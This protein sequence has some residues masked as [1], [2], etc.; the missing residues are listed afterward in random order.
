MTG[1]GEAMTKK[2]A[3][4]SDGTGNSSASP[5]KTNVWR[6]YEALDKSTGSNQIAFYDNGVGT[7][8]F[9][10]L[11]LLGLGLG[12]GLARNVK[13]IYA[14]LCQTYNDGDEIYC[15]G[16]SRG[17]FTIRVVVA[18]I[19]SQG[20]IDRN[21]A[22]DDRDL[23]RLVGDAY[24]AFR[25]ENF[26]PSILSWFLSPPR[27]WI[28]QFWNCM[29]GRGIYRRVDNIHFQT[30]EQQKN[31]PHKLIKFVGVWDSVDAY[32]LPVDEMTKA[33]DR[34][35]WPFSAKD[36]DLSKR[37]VKACH[38]LALDEQRESFE[39]MLW[40]E[41]AEN[42]TDL[43]VDNLD[44]Q[45][46]SQ[47]WFPGVHANVG[48]GYPDDTL[49]Y[50]SLNWILDASTNNNGL[51]YRKDIRDKYKSQA[52]G[53]LYNNRSGIA[54]LYRYAPR[55]IGA[56]CDQI[57][58]E[59]SN[60]VKY[61]F[62]N[63]DVELN[64][65]K[66]QKP[67]IHFSV[68]ERIKHGGDGYAPINLPAKYAI[69]DTAGHIF[70]CNSP[71]GIISV[72][73]TEEQ[74]SSRYA[75]QDFI[76][77]KVW[78]SRA[79]HFFTL[80]SAA[81]FIAFPYVT[82]RV[83]DFELGRTAGLFEAI[84]GV[85]MA[86]IKALPELVGQIPGLGFASGWAKKYSFFPVEFLF[87]VL[88]LAGLLVGNWLLGLS[89]RSEMRRNFYHLTNSGQPPLEYGILART[90]RDLRQS[91]VFRFVFGK[92]LSWLIHAASWIV[93][94]SAIPI[95][96][97]WAVFAALDGGGRV[98]SSSETVAGLSYEKPIV[99]EF[100]PK[101]PCQS[102][103]VYLDRGGE[104]KI[105]FVV[106]YNP[107]KVCNP[108]KKNVQ[109]GKDEWCY[110]GIRADVN[111][112]R[113][114]PWYMY[115]ATPFKRHLFADFY[116]PIARID[117]KLFT[118]YPLVDN[119]SPVTDPKIAGGGTPYQKRLCM[120]LK[121][122]RS[123]ELFFFVNDAVFLSPYWWPKLFCDKFEFFCN[124]RGMAQITI[125]RVASEGTKRK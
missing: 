59:F 103:K 88:L 105:E 77:N 102:S 6:A 33:W 108:V 30:A 8:S 78:R 111:G 109:P 2:I 93:F 71:K 101:E 74:A 95:A 123:G 56:L 35:V 87:G 34:V 107:K 115:L 41:A 55:D 76:W 83:A 79:V 42:P 39:P 94:V 75:Q 45:R 60:W 16:F 5:H 15:F 116:R 21:R 36:R 40:N 82:G 99:M 49:A 86:P 20:I 70:D 44:K 96:I 25:T 32:G 118:M 26:Q 28:L 119:C 22:K 125:S 100:N 31:T 92:S 12:F 98:C 110:R 47:V 66:I 69:V 81:C 65:V 80:F 104:Y 68:F 3:L 4:F 48:G 97:H 106:P 11:S 37:V 113:D 91:P 18:L 85:F 124:H 52:G 23:N 38:A 9:R 121:P 58:P 117:N 54:A 10:P 7:S 62:G 27:E 90:F 67:K 19:A 122:S 89:I 1:I 17:A 43:T 14:F 57:K 50:P 112:W 73:E 63:K 24:R 114:A 53:P 72:P 84:A 61:V 120:T 13:Q 64:R 46:L 29:R 51:K